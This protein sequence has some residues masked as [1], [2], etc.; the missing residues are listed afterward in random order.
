MERMA[1]K[2]KQREQL[3]VKTEARADA[4]N[5]LVCMVRRKGDGESGGGVL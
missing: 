5:Q 2:Q 1:L 3:N 4:T